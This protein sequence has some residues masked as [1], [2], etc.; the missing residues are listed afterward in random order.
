MARHGTGDGVPGGLNA[1]EH[2]DVN[3]PELSKKGRISE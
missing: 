3:R 1:V 2:P